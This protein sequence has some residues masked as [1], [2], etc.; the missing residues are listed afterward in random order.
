MSCEQQNRVLPLRL[1]ENDS[2]FVKH[3]WEELVEKLSSSDDPKLRII[4]FQE[5]EI[6]RAKE[7]VAKA[8]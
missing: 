6:I 2:A 7:K 3:E 5:S 8:S 1:L 4:G